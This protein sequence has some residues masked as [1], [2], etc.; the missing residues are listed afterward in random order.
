MNRAGWEWVAVLAAGGALGIAARFAWGLVL[1][2][3]GLASAG[4]PD[5]LPSLED[6]DGEDSLSRKVYL[7]PQRAKELLRDLER[8][9]E[10]TLSE[11]DQ[12]Y[13]DRRRDFLEYLDAQRE[14]IVRDLQRRQQQEQQQR[15]VNHTKPPGSP[16]PGAEDPP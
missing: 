3:L 5:G 8:K 15:T 4:R 1:R 12:R 11:I 14:Q 10:Q 16:P 13:A 9:K 7:E 6:L 2:L